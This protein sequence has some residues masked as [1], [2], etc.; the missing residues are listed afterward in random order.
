MSPPRCGDNDMQKPLLLSHIT[1]TRTPTSP[2][3]PWIDL[4]P[5]TSAAVCPG[6]AKTL[7]CA[8]KAGSHFSLSLS[9]GLASSPEIRSVW[10]T[11]RETCTSRSPS[12]SGSTPTVMTVTRSKDRKPC[13][14]CDRSPPLPLDLNCPPPAPAVE[15]G[16]GHYLAHLSV[17]MHPQD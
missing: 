8:A 1:L 15:P 10:P 2:F 9:K 13:S 11:H 6:I 17:Q 5:S 7:P 3:T 12:A 16:R 4:L 14:T